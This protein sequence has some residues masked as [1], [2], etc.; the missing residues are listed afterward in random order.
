MNKYQKRKLE[1]Y[2]EQ[3]KINKEILELSREQLKVNKESIEISRKQLKLNQELMQNK[4]QIEF[5]PIP[6]QP[7]TTQ[8]N[9]T[10]CNDKK[11]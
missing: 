2:E 11:S 8:P 4:K 5:V 6:Y 9:I 1:I 7:S 3:L 10:Y